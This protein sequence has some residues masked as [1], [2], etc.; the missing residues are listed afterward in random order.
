MRIRNNLSWGLYLFHTHTQRAAEGRA[1]SGT[2]IPMD[3]SWFTRER[4]PEQ[5]L[6]LD[7]RTG[8]VSAGIAIIGGDVT[9]DAEPEFVYTVRELFDFEKI[10]KRDSYVDAL[11]IALDKIGKALRRDGFAAMH[12]RDPKAEIDRVL[13]AVAA[14]WSHTI[15][16]TQT[17]EQEQPF[18]VT[19]GLLA[20]LAL[21]SAR[22]VE[23]DVSTFESDHG[24]R[25]SIAAEH[26]AHFRA[27][28][29]PVSDPVK[30]RMQT[31]ALTHLTELV[32]EDVADAIDGMLSETLSDIPVSVRGFLPLLAGASPHILPPER[33]ALAADIGALGTELA[34]TS[35]A[36]ILQTI[37]VPLGTRTLSLDIS[38]GSNGDEREAAARLAVYANDTLKGKAAKAVA[39]ALARHHDV[40]ETALQKLVHSANLPESILYADNGPAARA[41]AKVL[42]SALGGCAGSV[43]CRVASILGV[44]DAEA[45]TDHTAPL[46][47]MARYATRDRADDGVLPRVVR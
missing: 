29:Y 4:A 7:V 9:E 5:V 16:R 2:M 41:L 39:D 13:V 46:A 14:P 10:P 28:G 8:S 36:G 35:G 47:A 24:G 30:H 20:D 11:R 23:A 6:L 45:A 15:I 31:L 43:P 42:K 34:L 44:G 38:G 32:H 3:F 22:A 18:A 25:Y 17:Y 40:Y 1:R 26:L 21:T 37:F 12:E 19:R 27:N 33:H